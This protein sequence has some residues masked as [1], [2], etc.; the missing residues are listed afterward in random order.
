MINNFLTSEICTECNEIQ[1][2]Y[3]FCHNHYNI[4]KCDDILNNLYLFYQ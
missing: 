4:T 1:Y 3:G 2:K